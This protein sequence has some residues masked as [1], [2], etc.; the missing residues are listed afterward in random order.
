MNLTK[1]VNNYDINFKK[2][3][4][5]IANDCDIVD[6]SALVWTL[7]CYEHEFYGYFFYPF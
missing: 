7:V 4:N 2:N 6:V 5:V 1:K 3:F